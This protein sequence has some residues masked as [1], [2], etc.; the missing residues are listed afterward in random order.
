MAILRDGTQRKELRLDFA[1]QVQ[2]EPRDIPFEATDASRLDIRIVGRDFLDQPDEL[3]GFDV[4]EI[5]YQAV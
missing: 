1:L 5:Q 4:L 3:S 2:N